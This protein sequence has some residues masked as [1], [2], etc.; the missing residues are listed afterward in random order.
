MASSSH[1]FQRQL[2]FPKGFLHER[3]SWNPPLDA[4]LG[5]GSCSGFVVLSTSC[6][7]KVSLGRHPRERVNRVFQGTRPQPI[8]GNSPRNL[9]LSGSRKSLAVFRRAADSPAGYEF[10]GKEK[11]NHPQKDAWEWSGTE[12]P[13][14][15]RSSGRSL[16]NFQVE[17]LPLHLDSPRLWGC[18]GRGTPL[19]WASQGISASL[20]FLPLSF[21]WLRRQWQEQ[22]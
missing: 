2:P 21:L 5:R 8:T 15:S 17:T 11:L 16:R 19:G 10:L 13:G 14:S 9:L 22:E 1:G 20:F 4:V 18:H 7:S 12:G 6:F 3:P